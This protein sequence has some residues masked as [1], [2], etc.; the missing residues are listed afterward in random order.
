VIT[1][2]GRRLQ[3]DQIFLSSSLLT[4]MLYRCRLPRPP[5]DGFVESIWL[6]QNE[7]QAHALERLLPTGAAQLIVN[8][9]EDRVRRYD[10]ER[11]NR[12]ET[13]CGTVLAAVQS[14]FSVIDTAEQEHVMGVVFKPGGTVPFIRMPAHETCDADVP[15]DLVWDR[16]QAATLRERLL[17]ADGPDAKVDAMERA[18]LE[19]WRPV[20]PHPAVTFALQTVARRPP[21]ASVAAV[22]GA[23]G[24]SAKRFIERFKNE[25]G[26][27][28]K[29]YSRI[30]RFQRALARAHSH[31]RVDWSALAVDCGYFDQAHFVPDFRGFS[32]LTPTAYQA[33]RTASPNH[34]KFLQDDS[35]R[36]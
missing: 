2:G 5:L 34:V 33:A 22:T 9:K 6:W 32:G 36:L 17:E 10:P 15:L 23:I 3:Y 8:L 29:Q 21:V 1:H 4:P 20:A 14:R 27:T 26:L 12:C 16:S 28:P 25:V 19:A 31:D 11:G 24:L 18:L 7:P 13:T 30:R 35:G